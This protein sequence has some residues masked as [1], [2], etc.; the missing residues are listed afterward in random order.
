MVQVD[1]DGRQV[2]I[3]VTG[4]VTENNQRGLCPVIGRARRLVPGIQ[5]VVDLRGAES[6]EAAAM[7]LLRWSAEHE[8]PAAG[9]RKVKFL[10]ASPGA[11]PAT[12]TLEDARPLGLPTMHA[13]PEAEVTR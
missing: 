5:V 8:N 9:A 1:L 7:D 13:A 6:V 11:A 10:L 3:E 4:A 12:S 2:R